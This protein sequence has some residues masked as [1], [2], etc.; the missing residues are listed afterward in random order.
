M[1]CDMLNSICHEKEPWKLKVGV[2]R[3]WAAVE[4]NNNEFTSFSMILLDDDVS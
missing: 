4:L 1:T 3:I 2:I